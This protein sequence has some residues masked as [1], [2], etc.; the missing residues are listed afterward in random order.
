VIA[1]L[2]VVYILEI[3]RRGLIFGKR[4]FETKTLWKEFSQFTKKYHGYVASFGIVYDYWYHPFE[5]T[6]GHLTG[7]MFQFLLFWQ[8][9]LLFHQNHR[10]RYWTAFVESFV[11][12]HA[13]I[14]A[15]FQTGQVNLMFLFGFLFTFVMIQLWGLPIVYNYLNLPSDETIKTKRW[16]ML[17]SSSLILYL[18]CAVSTYAIAGAIAKV[19]MIINI[20]AM[21]YMSIV[22]VL[23]LHTIHNSF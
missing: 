6:A 23:L 12:I 5:V 3:P 18:V 16:R 8:S 11:T 1:L 20:P 17:F 4:P 9:S 2:V 22:S 14:T 19:W 21:L 15:I 10:N 7:F 13:F